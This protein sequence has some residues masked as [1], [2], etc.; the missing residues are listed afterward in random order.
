MKLSQKMIKAGWVVNRHRDGSFTVFGSRMQEYHYDSNTERWSVDLSVIESS[1]EQDLAEDSPVER[2]PWK[3][4]YVISSRLTALNHTRQISQPVRYLCQEGLV[5]DKTVLHLGTGMDRFAR[6]ALIKAGCRDVADY[7]PNFFPDTS[8]LDNQYDIVMAHYVLNILPP[9]ERRQV[10]RLI[11]NTLLE[12]GRAYLTVQGIWPVEHKY[13]I[14]RP[15]E[16][17]YLIKTGYNTTFRKGYSSED[18]LKEIHSELGGTA[19]LM[20][21]FYS[22]TMAF[23]KKSMPNSIHDK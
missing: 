4:P 14:I 17:G 5:S 20:T 3:S 9:A 10:Y 18:L 2:S 22:N 11:G 8:V 1:L 12:G 19:G 13:E 23:W 6:E 21:T 15:Q 7:D 16:D